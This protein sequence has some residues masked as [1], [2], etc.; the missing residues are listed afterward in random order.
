MAI[1]GSNI[2]A[3]TKATGTGWEQWVGQLDAGGAREL[4]HKPLAS[5]AYEMMP[6]ELS[7]PGWWA[8]SVAIAYEQHI[9]R[10]VPGQSS[11]GTFKGSVSATIAADLDGAL[12]RWMDAIGAQTDFNGTQL[13]GEAAVSGSERWRYWKAEFSDGSRV[14]VNISPKGDKASVSAEHSRLVNPQVLDGWKSF[15][16]QILATARD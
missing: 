7:N 11:D 13:V 10:R 12:A 8:Q 3:I 6:A 1:K 2:D 4:A 16:R 15:W 14:S 9:G 5:L